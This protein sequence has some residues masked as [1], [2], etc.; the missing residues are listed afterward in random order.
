M[1]RRQPTGRSRKSTIIWPRKKPSC[2]T[3][4]RA[5]T[6]GNGMS[7]EVPLRRV[8][9]KLGTGVLTSAGGEL[10]QARIADICAQLAALRS[11]GTEVYVVSSGAIGLGMAELRL[12]RRPKELSKKQA[13]AAIGQSL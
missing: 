4:E 1:S 10:D 7:H 5:E 6:L 11:G 2:S 3:F 9:V 13:C 8:V 12:E